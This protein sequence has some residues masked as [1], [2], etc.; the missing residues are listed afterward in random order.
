[1]LEVVD[2]VVEVLEVVD[3]SAVDVV[4]C[5]VVVLGVVVVVVVVVVLVVEVG[6]LVVVVTPSADGV[7]G[8][9]SHS[10]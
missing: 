10:G 2:G 6:R 9:L 1:M 7:L 4:I 8:G 5:E 3:I